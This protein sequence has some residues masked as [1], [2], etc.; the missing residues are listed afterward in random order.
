[1][2]YPN[3]WGAGAL[4]AYSGLDGTTSYAHGLPGILTAGRCGRDVPHVTRC[5]AAAHVPV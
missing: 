4:F 1:M 2:L 3:V 5:A